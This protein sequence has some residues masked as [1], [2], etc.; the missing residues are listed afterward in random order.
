MTQLQHNKQSFHALILIKLKPGGEYLIEQ[1]TQMGV[2]MDKYKTSELGKALK[3]IFHGTMTVDGGV[4]LAEKEISEVFA[5]RD[6][7]AEDDFDDGFIGDEI[8]DC[9]ICGKKV[10]R[11]TFGYGCSGYKDGCKLGLNRVICGRVISK[12]NVQMLLTNGK[13]SKIKGFVSK[14]GK[15][16]DAVLKLDGTNAKFDF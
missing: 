4:K 8:G 13:T 3:Q 6:L 1:L 9:P 2:S 10:R 16:F 5:K 12:K 15:P 14:N 7:P 11:T